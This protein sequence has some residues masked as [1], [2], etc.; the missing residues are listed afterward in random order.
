MFKLLSIDIYFVIKIHSGFIYSN[1][2]ESEAR[3]LS[4]KNEKNS[5]KRGVTFVDYLL[6]K[7]NLYWLK[8]EENL[9]KWFDHG[10][11]RVI[12]EQMRNGEFIQIKGTKKKVI[13]D[14]KQYNKS[15]NKWQEN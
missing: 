15:S 4:N 13:E 1:G 14:K 5:L 8:E 12:N 3:V 2:Y 9:L 7:K 10:K 6:K 11:R